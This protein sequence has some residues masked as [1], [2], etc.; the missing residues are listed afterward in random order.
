MKEEQYDIVILGRGA[1]SFSA[2]IKASELTGGEA[3]IAMIGFGPI[4]GTCVNV[5]CVPSKYLL[6]ASHRV[7][8]PGIPR[9]KGISGQKIDFNFAAVMKGLR[10]FVKSARE[11]KYEGVIKSYSN[12]TVF[13]GKGRFVSE[14]TIEVVNNEGRMSAKLK[15]SSIIVAVGS[16]PAIPKI[17][18]LDGVQFLTSDN[19]WRIESL[20][21]SVTVIGGGS[22]GIELGQA[23]LHFGSEVTVIEAM[24]DILPQT[25]P[26]IAKALRQR[27]ESEGMRFHLKSQI[28]QVYSKDGK[29]FTEVINHKGLQTIVSDSLLV[30]AGRVPNTN[31][32]GL[33]NA[34]IKTDGRGYIVTDLNMRTSNPRV[35]AAGDCVAKTLYLETLAARE[36]VIAAENIFGADSQVDY[37]STPWAV[38]T[39]PQIAGVGEREADY[40]RRTGACSCRILPLSALTKASIVGETEG[41]IKI[42]TDPNSGRIAG[43]QVFSPNATDIITEGSYAIRHRLSIGEIIS[44]GHIF[45]SFSEGIKLAAQAFIR[46]VSKMSCCVE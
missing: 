4:G 32:L 3:R 11:G 17:P 10:D 2:A 28:K 6:E 39:S 40:S 46:D 21:K 41:L 9:I 19:I 24:S 45:P 5:G 33:E 43:I 36:G 20:P 7:F 34:G 35:Y 1:A 23:L 44:T 42:T 18:G 38:F 13:E 26:E 30:A 25:E 14:D 15:G 29:I 31:D 8:D 37:N 16:K 22:I 27:L 12:V